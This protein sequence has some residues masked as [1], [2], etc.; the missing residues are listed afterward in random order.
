MKGEV[1]S[2]KDKYMKVLKQNQEKFKIAFINKYGCDKDQVTFTFTEVFTE[3][4]VKASYSQEFI[5]LFAND[6]LLFQELNYDMS[7]PLQ[8]E[9]F[10]EDLDEFMSSDQTFY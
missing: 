7:D 4:K 3:I 9:N 1:P 5:F 8:F 6:K 10:Y 2:L